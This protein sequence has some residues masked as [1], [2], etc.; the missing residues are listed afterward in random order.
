MWMK[1]RI[2]WLRQT[3][4]VKEGGCS[5]L[6]M[7]IGFFV[8]GC[9]RVWFGRVDALCWSMWIYEV[10]TMTSN[11]GWIWISWVI[12]IL[13]D[14]NQWSLLSVHA[15]SGVDP[16]LVLRHADYAWSQ[17]CF[18][19]CM[20]GGCCEFVFLFGSDLCHASLHT[21]SEPDAMVCGKV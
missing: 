1:Q 5:Y 9:M 11:L 2:S 17:R 16:C 21:K 3:A 4:C 14:F 15:W 18:R 7:I 13:L 19:C 12:G 6:E 8:G 20:L 10:N